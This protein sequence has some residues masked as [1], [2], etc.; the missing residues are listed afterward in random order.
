M[1]KKLGVFLISIFIVCCGC[2]SQNRVKGI[3]SKVIVVNVGLRQRFALAKEIELIRLLN[4]KVIGI[5]VSFLENQDQYSDSTL[6]S[7]LSKCD[8]LVMMGLIKDYDSSKEDYDELESSLPEFTANATIGF[9]NAVMD[10]DEFG[11]IRRFSISE[12]INRIRFF[13]FAVEVALKYDSAVTNGFIDRNQRI[14]DIQFLI[15]RR[16]S[17]REGV[18]GR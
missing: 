10:N 12:T 1:K 15:L 13:H 2:K 9:V 18:E 5:D 8:N 4:P 7:V 6:S 16:V 14:T 17:V 3:E 11:T